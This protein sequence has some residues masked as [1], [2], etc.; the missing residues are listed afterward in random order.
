MQ[1][2][3]TAKLCIALSRPKHFICRKN[4]LNCFNNSVSMDAETFAS[5]LLNRYLDI[6][7]REQ[8]VNAAQ[9][10]LKTL[11]DMN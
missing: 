10:H 7:G 4:Y 2:R 6:C 3:P 1:E 5:M 8:L 11:K 9:R